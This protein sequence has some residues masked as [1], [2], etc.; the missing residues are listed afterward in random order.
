GCGTNDRP[1]IDRSQNPY[2]SA[3]SAATAPAAGLAYA[4]L[5]SYASLFALANLL[6]DTSGRLAWYLP[7]NLPVAA[8]RLIADSHSALCSRPTPYPHAQLFLRIPPAPVSMDPARNSHQPTS[9]P[10]AQLVALPYVTHQLATRPRAL[11]L[12]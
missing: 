10:F 6:R 11:G 8:A 2:S 4:R 5:A 7:S 9:T 1:P 12:F 3:D